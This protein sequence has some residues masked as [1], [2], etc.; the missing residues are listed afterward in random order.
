MGPLAWTARF[1][2]C[3]GWKT[4]VTWVSHTA[5]DLCAAESAAGKGRPEHGGLVLTACILASSLAF[6]DGSVVNVGLPAI[7]QSLQGDPQGLQWVIN[8]YLLPLSALL[9]LGGAA[10]D[11]FGRRRVLLFG[12]VLFGVSSALCATS[13]NLAFLLAARAFQGTG[14]ALL[15]PSSLAILGNT[16]WGEARGRAV[17]TWSAA[18]AIG[19]AIGP[20]LGGWL[21]DVFGWRAIFLLN[22]PLALAA[23]GLAFVYIR[24]CV[25]G[26]ETP[27]DASGALLAAISLGLLTW[28]LTI[29]TGRGGWSIEAVAV[30]IAGIAL[31]AVFIGVEWRRG[32][33]AM[34]P[35]ALF[36]SPDFV[37]LSILTLLL[38]GA[39]GGL[40]VLV[41]FVLIEGAGFSATAAG[42]ALLPLPLILA[43]T[44]R[45]IGGL[46]VRIGSHLP[47]T[48]G[49]VIVAAG[50]LLFLLFDA[51]SN[52]WRG[53]LPAILMVAVGMA[54][55][56]APLTTAVLASVNARHTGAASGL[57]SALGRLGGLIATALIGAVIAAKGAAL[58]AAFHLA[59]IACA[60]AALAAGVAAFLL[61]GGSKNR[62]G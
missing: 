29:G 57:N 43:L 18:S 23:A 39:L 36:R 58:F 8:A 20:V 30:L 33:A 17:G 5:G 48:V 3:S 25:H 40:F 38:Y 47:L 53:V 10:G 61:V 6:V 51:G 19:G 60:I 62:L 24:D 9:L 22:I 32:D 52:Y 56:V 27:I 11:R 44:S 16:F 34:M 12:V 54:G 35:L 50:I 45:A 46:A 26:D 4:L 59:V 14:A 28:G 55:A 13:P 1:F 21:I 42:A 41:P 2:V 7:G 49:P 31:F 15:L 37:G